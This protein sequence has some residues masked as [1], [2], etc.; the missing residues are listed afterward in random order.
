MF[1][2]PGTK[3]PSLRK[4]IS[5]GACLDRQGC[6]HITEV[7]GSQRGLRMV[8]MIPS[9]QQWHQV[10]KE[11]PRRMETTLWEKGEEPKQLKINF[12]PLPPHPTPKEGLNNCKWND[13]KIHFYFL[14][15]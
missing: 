2:G 11:L 10:G 3:E 7:S 15:T 8:R 13:G 9:P 4:R 12:A 6:E 1:E 14:P 5:G